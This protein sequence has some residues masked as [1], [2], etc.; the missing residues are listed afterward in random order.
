MRT[1]MY[2]VHINKDGLYITDYETG[3][4]ITI[5]QYRALRAAINREEAGWA[6]NIA[7]LYDPEL[8]DEDEPEW[9]SRLS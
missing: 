7:A 6:S 1:D 2:T 9:G 3:K 4:E 5:G 8:L